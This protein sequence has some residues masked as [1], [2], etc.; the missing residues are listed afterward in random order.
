M[1]ILLAMNSN[2]ELSDKCAKEAA[3]E[4]INLNFDEAQPLS[5]SEIKK[6]IRSDITDCW[7]R[8]WDR[9]VSCHM[10][11]LIKSIIST[12]SI[13][14]SSDSSVDKRINRLKTGHSNLSEHRWKMKILDTSTPLCKCGESND[15]VE[16]FLFFSAHYI[17][18]AE[19][20]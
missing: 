9:Y 4:A 6:E 10:L 14:S 16:H 13:H 17:T 7:Q 18:S 5:F 19:K 20:K 2:L 15:N 12:N 11:H 3:Q 8:Q 1:L